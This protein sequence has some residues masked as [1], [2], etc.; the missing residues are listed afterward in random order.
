MVNSWN[1]SPQLTW[2]LALPNRGWGDGDIYRNIASVQSVSPWPTLKVACRGPTPAHGLLQLSAWE[3]S[4]HK[5]VL[6]SCPQR[7]DWKCQELTPQ[8]RPLTYEWLKLWIKSPT[9]SSL[10]RKVMKWIHMVFQRAPL[11]LSPSCP[12]YEDIDWQP[13]FG[14]V[15]AEALKRLIVFF[16]T[17]FT[18]SRCVSPHPSWRTFPS[19][20]ATK[21]QLYTGGLTTPCLIWTWVTLSV[22][23]F[24]GDPGAEY[25]W[26]LFQ[27]LT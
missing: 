16:H 27:Y 9:S 14:Y 7:T 8:E 20:I 3:F 22:S 24:L 21:S 5:T 4:S 1:Q 13:H 6:S 17:P 15:K 19:V 25:L 11:G 10:S 18:K 26:E 23:E 2:S 12:Q